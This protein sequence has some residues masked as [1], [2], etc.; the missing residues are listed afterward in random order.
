MGRFRMTLPVMLLLLPGVLQAQHKP[1][2]PTDLPDIVVTDHSSAFHFDLD[3][4]GAELSSNQPATGCG[5]QLC[6]PQNYPSRSVKQI[7]QRRVND[8]PFVFTK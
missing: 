5:T 7:K 3:M 2:Q 4:R 1:S 6:R 8:A